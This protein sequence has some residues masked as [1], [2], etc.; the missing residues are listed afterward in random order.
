M[1]SLDV[2][3]VAEIGAVTWKPTTDDDHLVLVDHVGTATAVWVW[4][5][6]VV[7]GECLDPRERWYGQDVGIIVGECTTKTVPSIQVTT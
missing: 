1:L 7:C 5:G 3:R 6:A 4:S 2:G